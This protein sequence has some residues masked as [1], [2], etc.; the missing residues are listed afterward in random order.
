MAEY[1]RRMDAS[2]RVSGKKASKL[3]CE[4]QPPIYML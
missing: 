3:G 4:I 2:V 1:E